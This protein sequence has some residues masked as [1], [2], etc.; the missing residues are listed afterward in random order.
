MDG[1]YSAQL[2][3][4][5]KELIRSLRVIATPKVLFGT[6]GA[7]GAQGQGTVFKVT[8]PAVIGDPWTE[9]TVFSF[10]NTGLDPASRSVIK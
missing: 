4:R 6:A 3:A 7:G 8:P 1:E 9:T 10:G 2:R 5:W